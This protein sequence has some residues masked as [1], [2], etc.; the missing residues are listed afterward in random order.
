[1][2]KIIASA[3]G[4][5]FLATASLAAEVKIGFV[6]TLTTPAAV[7]GKDMENAVNLAMEH[8]GGK[9]GSQYDYYGYYD[10]Y[11]YSSDE[12]STISE[13]TDTERT[14]TVARSA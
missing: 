8:L 12:D 10:Y 2:K 3:L 9:A 14:G 1:M 4:G 5:T 11:D 6:T 13:P 7:I